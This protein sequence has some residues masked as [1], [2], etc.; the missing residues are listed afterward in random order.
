VTY[1]VVLLKEEVGGYSV[2]VPALPG[3]FTQGETV[4]EALDNAKEAITCHVGALRADGDPVPSD[5][6]T[7]SFEWGGAEEA[8]AYRVTV[9]EA[10]AVA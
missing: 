4:S 8:L 7:V 2:I 10:V 5:V 9:G 6:E 1:T 3:C